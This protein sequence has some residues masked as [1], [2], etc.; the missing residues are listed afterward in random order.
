MSKIDFQKEEYKD[1]LLS[2][3]KK[4]CLKEK[5]K[6]VKDLE[7]K[8]SQSSFWQDHQKAAKVMQR[9]AEIQGEIDL[10]QDLKFLLEK[11]LSLEERE[12][13]L[14]KF[15]EFESQALFTGR[16]DSGEAI[17][18]IHAGQGGTEAC[19]WVQMLYRMYLKYG[20]KKGFK[21]EV[22]DERRG[23]EAGLKRVVIKIFGFRAYGMLKREKGAH[24]LVRQS[25]FNADS[26]RQTSFAL[27]EV[28]PVIEDED[29]SIEIKDDEIEFETFRSGGHGGQNVNKVSTAV[30]IKHK[31]TGIVVESQTQRHQ[32]QN[33]K[34]AMQ[35]L[36][37]KLW[38]IQ[39]EEKAKEMKAIKGQ[40]RTASWGNQIRSYVLHPYKMVKDV[41]TKHEESNPDL[42]L[43]GNLDGFIEAELRQLD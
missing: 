24:R 11:D 39:E 34:I 42:V 35:I 41:R 36:K 40:Y 25:P 4:L 30:R 29:E 23:E 20:E 28:L 33:R 18:S 43:D 22:I 31:A 7:E 10:F 26:L 1:K 17:L 14:K 27:V 2:L 32:E 12:S 16:Y 37:A 8:S 21:M 5:E 38:Q 9:L 15:K 6:E 13:F 3:E 19:D